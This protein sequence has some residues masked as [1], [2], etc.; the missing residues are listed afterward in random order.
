[1]SCSAEQM[2][3]ERAQVW[4]SRSFEQMQQQAADRVGRAAAVV[5][6]LGE[7]G[8]ALLRHVLAKASSRSWKQL[9]RQ[10]ML[11]NDSRD[12]AEQ[13]RLGGFAA[14]DALELAR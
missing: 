6:Q 3:S 9:Q 13:R 5:E 8:V 1:M 12:V 4:L 2:A 10:A 7:V 11:A 14:R